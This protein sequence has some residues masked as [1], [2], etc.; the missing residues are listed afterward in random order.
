MSKS[1][2][3]RFEIRAN[4][5]HEK[6]KR[7]ERWDAL[8]FYSFYSEAVF[9]ISVRLDDTECVKYSERSVV[10]GIHVLLHRIRNTNTELLEI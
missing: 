6:E 2:S 3:E 7:G 8:T 9:R 1:P 4:K 5:A 10:K